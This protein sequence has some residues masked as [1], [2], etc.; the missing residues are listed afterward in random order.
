[1][2]RLLK[3]ATTVFC[4]SLSA[5]AFGEPPVFVSS[6]AGLQLSDQ[7]K[8]EVVRAPQNLIVNPPDH[9][10]QAFESGVERAI[11]IDL[12]DKATASMQFTALIHYPPYELSETRSIEPTVVCEGAG[13][14]PQ[15]LSCVDN[16]DIYAVLPDRKRIAIND[17]SMTDEQITKI[18]NKIDEINYRTSTGTMVTSNGVN[19]IL[20]RSRESRVYAV[21]GSGT[22]NLRHT[23]VDGEDKYELTEWSCK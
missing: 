13:I 12:G 21:L 9:L 18:L 14:Q 16:S 1:M 6:D 4:L 2:T 22:I 19:H 7:E 8:V 10:L 11:V 3:L 5:I 17:L 23:V 15:W 20:L